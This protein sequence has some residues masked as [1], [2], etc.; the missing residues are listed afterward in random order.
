[1]AE[2]LFLIKAVPVTGGSVLKPKTNASQS[3]TAHLEHDPSS[4]A[5]T[6]Q[7]D[8]NVHRRLDSAR[9]RAA[10]PHLPR[11]GYALQADGHPL[12]EVKRRRRCRATQIVVNGDRSRLRGPREHGLRLVLGVMVVEA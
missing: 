8:P 7:K 9:Q 2:P 6:D 10:E 4:L 3:S 12:T 5:H 11:V 1:M